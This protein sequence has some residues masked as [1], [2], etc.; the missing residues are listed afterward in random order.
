MILPRTQERGQYPRIPKPI[1]LYAPGCTKPV[2]FVNLQRRLL[3]KTVD[4]HRHFVRIPPGIAFDDGV[5]QQASDYGVTD[6]EVIDGTSPHRDT[7]RCTLDTFLRHAEPVN[8]G[9]GRQLA[10]RFSYWRKNGQPSEVER[11]AEQQ[12]AR[13]EAAG[14]KQL[15][16]FGGAA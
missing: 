11:Q 10:L 1:P 8:R 4:G 7:Y 15:E 9:H 16:L 6:I 12:A 14:M 13:A 3:Y 5:L 2:A